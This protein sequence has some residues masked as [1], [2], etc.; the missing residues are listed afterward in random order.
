MHNITEIYI[1]KAHIDTVTYI[2]YHIHIKHTQQY[3]VRIQLFVYCFYMLG[4]YICLR[5]C[6]QKVV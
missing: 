1:G 2:L 3:K 4:L 5:K 6:T